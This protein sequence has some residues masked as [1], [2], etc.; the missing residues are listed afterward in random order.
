[1]ENRDVNIVFMGTPDFAVPALAALLD[2]GYNIK[3]V[4][5]APDKE[6]GRGRKIRFSPVK[7]FALEKGLNV[8]QP[9]KLKDPAFIE[10]LR[11][12]KPDLQVVVAFRM[13][14]EIVWSMPRLGTFNLHASL[15]PQYRGAAPINHAIMRGEKVTGLTTFFLDKEIDTGKIIHQVKMEIGE[16]EDFGHLHDRMM[17]EGAKLVVRTV[18]DIIHN[19]VVP[20]PQ[21]ELY[22]DT[23]V[24][25]PAPKLFKEDCRIDWKDTVQTI[26]NKVRGLSPYP[27][28]FTMM[29]LKNGEERMMKIYRTRPEPDQR[30]GQTGTFLSDGKTFLKVSAGDGFVHLLEV[31]LQGKKRLTI[32]EFLRGFQVEKIEN[33]K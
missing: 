30:S 4:I 24:L 21:D 2:A 8:L 5:T 9:V 26:H 13:L 15:L 31:Q 16:D 11:E 17:E 10:Q 27:A 33:F 14:P 6:A 20:V 32:Q 25:Y 23:G 28:A 1:M 22:K 29:K 7:A 19:R 18:E 12:L 3:G